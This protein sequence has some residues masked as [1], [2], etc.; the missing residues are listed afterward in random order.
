MTGLVDR[1]LVQAGVAAVMAVLAGCL[2]PA[3]DAWAFGRTLDEIF[4][5]TVRR[6]NDGHLPRYI[7]NR[8]LPPIPERKPPTPEQAA[9]QARMHGPGIVEFE[10][11]R[12]MAWV[13]VVQEVAKGA[14]GPFAVEEVRRRARAQDP[15]AVELLAWMH[16][17]GVG[18]QPD[19]RAAFRLY[20]EADA[21]GVEGAR[22]NAGA[23]YR[24]M[25]V[26]ERRGLANPF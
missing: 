25:N 9:A 8:G 22:E 12:P 5:D 13:D 21:L 3:A 14:P 4:R 7:I 24:S 10:P 16:A 18:V 26:E 11:G 17:N 23:V 20:L 2:C 6:E 1:R 19:L 15:Q